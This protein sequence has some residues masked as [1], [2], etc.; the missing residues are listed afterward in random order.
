[1]LVFLAA[2]ARAQDNSASGNQ[3]VPPPAAATPAKADDTAPADPNA[4]APEAASPAP[5]TVAPASSTYRLQ[6][7]DLIDVEVYNEPDLHRPARLGSDGSALLPLIGTVKLGG[8]TVAQADAEVTKR[9]A[10]GFVKDPN[11]MITVTQ[12]RKSTFSI[13]G[14]VTH[15]GIFDIPEGAHVSILDAISMAG[16]FTAGAA[17]NAV[18]VKRVAHGKVTLYKVK[19]AD[20]AQDPNAVFELMPGDTVIVSAP[21]AG[22]FSILGQVQKPGLYPIPAGGHVSIIDAVSLAGGYSPMAAQNAITVKRRVNGHEQIIP[23]HAGDIALDPNAPPFEVLPGDSI[24]VPYR[25]ST[26]SVLGQVTRPGIYEIPEGAHV[27]IVEAILMAGGYT[28]TAAQNSVT[29]KRV[30]NGM[31]ETVKVRAGD[32]AQKADLVPFEVLPGDIVK[33]NESW[34]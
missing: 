6:P 23:V 5:S 30:V 11:V 8:M 1:M 9:Y 20:M 32:M 16:G 28:R 18:T 4:A 33:V 31:T 25:N 34:Y 15:A 24:L 19:A 13:L 22:G 14:Q 21:P 26:F 3:I 17:A 12:F 29:V 27:N 7:Y 10:A 2:A